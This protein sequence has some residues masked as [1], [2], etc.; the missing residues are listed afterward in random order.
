MYGY[1]YLY[2]DL[3]GFR[4]FL[5]SVFLASSIFMLQSAGSK[6]WEASVKMRWLPLVLLM[7]AKAAQVGKQ[8]GPVPSA[9]YWE[10]RLLIKKSRFVVRM[11]P[12]TTLDDAKAFRSWV[13][14]P[15]ANHNCWA[16]RSRG[17]DV[18]SSDDGEPAGTAGMPMRSVLLGAGLFGA[19]VVVT[20]Y[21]GGIKLGTGGLVRAYGNATRAVL[22][23]AHLEDMVEGVTLRVSNVPASQA[24]GKR[25][26]I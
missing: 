8:L 1:R 6:P 5:K 9:G 21:F 26:S 18:A 2:R 25:R 4:R 12:C 20:R 17:G 10:S 11:G 24:G 23:G 22:E 3:K 14:D 19:V 13:S 16:A 7:R 15:K